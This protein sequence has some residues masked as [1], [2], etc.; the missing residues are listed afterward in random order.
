MEKSIC[1]RHLSACRRAFRSVAVLLGLAIFSSS[2]AVALP[3]MY[4]LDGSGRLGTVD[5]GSGDVELIGDLG[6]VLTD[7]AFDPFGNLFGLSSSNLYLINAD[8]AAT[9]YIGAHGIEGANALVFS[10]TGELYAAGR[11]STNL[12]QVDTATG[13][14]SSLGDMGFSSAGDLAF[15]G[16]GFFLAAKSNRLVSVD[17]DNLANSFT[18]GSF[19]I[20]SVFGLATG[21]DGVLYSVAHTQICQTSTLTGQTSNCVDYT[22]GGLDTAFGEAFYTESGAEDPIA[23][24]A[25]VPVPGSLL[26]MSLGL[27][28]FGWSRKQAG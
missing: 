1:E 6:R 10:E 16:D 13:L 25:L 8:T 5:A 12:Y 2:S 11:S 17:L 9:S 4:V 21:E 14:G 23:P 28:G 22:D 20:S 19:G 27:I 26:L 3:I 24:A 15:N 18:V 7:I